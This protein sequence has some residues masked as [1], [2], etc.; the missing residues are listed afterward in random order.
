MSS[1]DDAIIASRSHVIHVDGDDIP[2]EHCGNTGIAANVT[3]DADGTITIT[4]V[5][6][7]FMLSDEATITLRP[8]RRPA[9]RSAAPS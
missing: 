9:A 6:E 7:K 3:I 5:T 4:G 8:N 1:T 2:P